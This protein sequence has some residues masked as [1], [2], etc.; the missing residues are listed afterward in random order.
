[1]AMVAPRPVDAEDIGS[2]QCAGE[3]WSVLA[4]PHIESQP[5]PQLGTT[6][7]A[8]RSEY[9]RVMSAFG[10]CPSGMRTQAVEPYLIFNACDFTD[11]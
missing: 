2:P 9:E 10:S 3:L 8:L 7:G 1:M 5:K 4:S 6:I 11:K